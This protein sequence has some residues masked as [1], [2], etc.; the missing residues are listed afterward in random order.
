MASVGELVGF[1]DGRPPQGVLGLERLLRPPAE[2]RAFSARTVSLEVLEELHALMAVG[3]GMSGASPTHLIFAATPSAK[4]RLARQLAPRTRD[5][6]ILAPVCA[7][8]G[9][10]RQ[11]AEHLI[12]FVGDGVGG[13]SCFDRPGLLRATAMRNSVLQGAYLALS[14]RAL[15]LEATF[16]HG[17]DG[18][19]VA[20]E[21]FANG[22]VSAIFVAAVGYPAL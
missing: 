1:Q 20:E 21:F 18:A 12:A 15:G 2:G 10:D 11:F 5:A 9:Y 4:G 22:D 3:P 6:A 8:I 17:F 13:E 14:A 7:I 16:L 19:A